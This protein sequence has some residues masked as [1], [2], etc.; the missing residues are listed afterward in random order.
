MNNA[1]LKATNTFDDDKKVRPAVR[2]VH[3]DLNHN[4]FTYTF[5]KHSLTILTLKLS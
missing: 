2:N 5:P 1:D 3:I 4:G